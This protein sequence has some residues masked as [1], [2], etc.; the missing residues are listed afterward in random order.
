M[1]DHDVKDK[2]K[3]DD[4]EKDEK[5]EAATPAPVPYPA[6]RYKAK[7]EP[8][9]PV[10]YDAVI[11]QSEEEEKKL[12]KGWVDNPGKLEKTAAAKDKVEEL[13]AHKTGPATPPTPAKK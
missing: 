7:P 10:L 12:G 6:W 1:A 13:S 9:D 8:T 4:D 11:V 5:D 3:K 2:D